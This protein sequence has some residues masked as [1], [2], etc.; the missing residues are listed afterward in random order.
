MGIFSHVSFF[1]KGEIWK[2]MIIF[3]GQNWEINTG[4]NNEKNI[5]I[6]IYANDDCVV[7]RCQSARI[8]RWKYY[9]YIIESIFFY[10]LYIGTAN[11]GDF[12]TK[13]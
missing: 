13:I 1:C 2:I 10:V 11:V 6:C 9:I 5:V 7:Q 3:A 8:R 4:I 12:L